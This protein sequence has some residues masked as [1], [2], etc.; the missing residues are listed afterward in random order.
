MRNQAKPFL[1]NA[2]IMTIAAVLI[3]LLMNSWGAVQVIIVILVA[4]LAAGQW[5]LY[6][7]MRKR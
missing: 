3:A 5:A 6:F 4:L 2:V 1:R 7:Y